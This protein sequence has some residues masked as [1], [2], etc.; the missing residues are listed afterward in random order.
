M[1]GEQDTTGERGG[2]ERETKEQEESEQDA[3]NGYYAR[4]KQERGGNQPRSTP[5]PCFLRVFTFWVG[6][7]QFV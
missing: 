6:C 1:R 2:E 4:E 5:V 7:R 3:N